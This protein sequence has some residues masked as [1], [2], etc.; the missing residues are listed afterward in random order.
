M[1]S[2]SDRRSPSISP[3]EDAHQVV[4]RVLAPVGDHGLRVGDVLEGHLRRVPAAFLGRE[5]ARRA[6][7]EQLVGP[8]QQLVSVL[9]L[10]AEQ[11]ADHDH[12]QRGRDLGDELAA[13]LRQPDRSARADRAI[14]GSWAPA[15]CFVKPRFTGCAAA[16]DPGHPR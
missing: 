6:P 10:D 11:I 3:D 4:A 1:I 16:C 12:R 7:A 15:R 14:F 5:L 9:G 8:V 13:P 2:S